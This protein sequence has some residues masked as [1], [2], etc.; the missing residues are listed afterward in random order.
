M[1]D[2]TDSADALP[3]VVVSES[4]AETLWPGKSAIGKRVVNAM[5]EG[6]RTVVGVVSDARMRGLGRI[7]AEMLRDCY[8]SFDQVPASRANVFLRTRSDT[9]AM[10]KMVR[11][12]VKEIDPTR[13]VFEVST[14]QE[15]MAEDVGEMRFTTTLMIL[16]AGAAVLLT[17]LG[18]YSVMSYS[19]SR[20]TRE[21]G[22]RVALGA[23][24]GDI[25][26]LVL[27]QAII[28]LTIGIAIGVVSALA[29]SRIMSSLL[30]GVTPT[31]PIAFISIVPPLVAVAVAAAFMP[32]R[33]ALAVEPSEALRYE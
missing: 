11:N 2:G 33:R 32:V 3:S 22:V 4:V 23:K 29:L 13:A 12:A 8:I 20:R 5:G 7:H 30:Y 31:D 1:I 10:V 21:I 26:A 17:A 28:D 15:S 24:R 25:V 16:F 18:I 9:A 27:N 19:A 14:M 6:W